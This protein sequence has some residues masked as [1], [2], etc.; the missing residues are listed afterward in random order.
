MYAILLNIKPNLMTKK[1]KGKFMLIKSLFTITLV[2]LATGCAS[3]DSL[4]QQV[5]TLSNKVDKLT[6]EISKLKAQQDKNTTAIDTLKA[7]S[8]KTNQRINNVAKS[9]KK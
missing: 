5:S 2:A 4:D 3:S 1:N 7:S 6:M 8:E 9:Y